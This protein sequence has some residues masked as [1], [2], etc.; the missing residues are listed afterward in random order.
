LSTEVIQR[1]QNRDPVTSMVI[2]LLSDPTRRPTWED[3]VEA[4]REVQLLYAQWQTLE[5]R[6]EILYRRYENPDGSVRFYQIVVPRK[7]RNA[8]MAEVHGS[9]TAGHF[10]NIKCQ[11]RLM[12]YAYW[13][14]WKSDLAMFIR[15]CDL[16]NT[17]K[18]NKGR[19]GPLQY[20]SV[21]SAWQKVHV[22][23]MGSF[24]R[25]YDGF[26][27]ILTVVHR[28]TKYLIA[29]PLRNKKAQTVARALV[30]NVDTWGSRVA[31]L[32]PGIGIL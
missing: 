9:T 7:L 8:F 17:Y 27:Y 23:L 4:D 30:K 29:V 24:V 15:R 12:H 32:R 26:E 2:K 28:F 22:D 16:C 20:A 11:H 21:S 5:L 6:N 3:V 19:Q 1:K 14:N 25:S 31:S 18:R 10:G 13:L